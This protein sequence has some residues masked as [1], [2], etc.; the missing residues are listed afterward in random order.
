MRHG[1]WLHNQSDVFFIFISH[2]VFITVLYRTVPFDAG[3]VGY[4]LHLSGGWERGETTI[5]LH[6]RTWQVIPCL[7]EVCHGV[8]LCFDMTLPWDG[9]FL[10][11]SQ[12]DRY[13]EDDFLRALDTYKQ[14]SG[15][16]NQTLKDEFHSIQATVSAH[17]PDPARHYRPAC[18]RLC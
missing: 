3:G 13:F 16:G 6:H 2:L 8:F 10:L 11:L 1:F 9:C 12:I 17:Q 15:G 7:E 4:G 5:S 18:Q 14:S